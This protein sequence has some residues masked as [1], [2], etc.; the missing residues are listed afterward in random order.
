M[1][2]IRT[3]LI[4]AIAVALVVLALLLVSKYGSSLA[5]VHVQSAGAAAPSLPATTDTTAAPETTT[6]VAPTLP[7]GSSGSV[8]GPATTV[9]V[10]TTVA[11]AP[12]PTPTLATTAPPAPPTT[13]LA[14]QAPPT[15]LN[16]ETSATT[17]PVVDCTH[18]LNC[19]DANG[20]WHNLAPCV[21]AGPAVN[22]SAPKTPQYPGEQ[23]ESTPCVDTQGVQHL[24]AGQ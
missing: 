4:A 8:S 6:T 20:V 11:P 7:T 18:Q 16:A 19:R 2:Q 24:P 15:T 14:T 10:A 1:K 9:P 12:A 5:T 3:A 13:A 23:P 22:G 17:D 21:Y